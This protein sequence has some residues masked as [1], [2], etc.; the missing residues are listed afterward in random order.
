LSTRSRRIERHPIAALTAIL[1]ALGWVSAA[2]VTFSPAVQL[3]YGR[4]GNVAVTGNQT[5]TSDQATRLFAS[6]AVRR[7]TANSDFDFA[8]QPSFT[9]YNQFTSLDNVAH[10]LT[11]NLNLTASRNTTYRLGFIAERT[12]DQGYNPEDPQDPVSLV[13]RTRIDRGALILSSRIMTGTNTYWNWSL[14][15]TA[16]RF[17]QDFYE[18][19][20]SY[21]AGFGWGRNLSA[22]TTMGVSYRYRRVE[23]QT[24]EPTAVHTLQFD[25]T[26]NFTQSITGT[27]GVG[28][29]HLITVLGDTDDMSLTLRLS[30]NIAR[31]FSFAVGAG[32]DASAGDGLRGTTIDRG[33]FTDFRW[34]PT[35]HWSFRTGLSFWDR[36]GLA[37]VVLQLPGTRTFLTR[38]TLEWRPHRVVALGLFHTYQNQDAVGVEDPILDA[39]FHRGGLFVRWDPKGGAATQNTGGASSSGGS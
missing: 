36:E 16:N 28:V 23:F 18:D 13:P 29:F 39:D 2:E 38:T 37:D 33:L 30:K 26:R 3:A 1:G 7:R 32:Q 34:V 22:K 4:D 12:E 19:S 35:T 17:N 9:A 11:A 14:G 5:S 6:L 10:R 20:E 24:F 25:A 31:G 27:L 15:A 21:D 8:Y